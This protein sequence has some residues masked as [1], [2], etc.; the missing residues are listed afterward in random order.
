MRKHRIGFAALT[1]ASLCSAGSAHGVGTLA[2]SGGLEPIEQRLALSVG[3]ARTTL[4]TSTRLSADGVFGVVVPAPVGASLDWSSSA[5]FESLE[6]ATAPRLFPPDGVNAVC[7][8]DGVTH[9][10]HVVGALEHEE[11]L[12]PLDVLILADASAVTLWAAQAGLTVTPELATGLV[13][14]ESP[15]M[16]FVAALFD[17]PGGEVVT[18]TLRISTP[19]GNPE[20]PMV[21]T[22]AGA[23]D[24]TV[25]A[26]L[27]AEGRA[28]I[29]LAPLASVDLLEV[30]FEASG[31]GS[32]YVD[33]RRDAL[34]A[35]GADSTV[36][37]SASHDSLRDNTSIAEGTSS[38][39]GVVTAFFARASVYGDG[40]PDPAQ[41]TAI[42][43]ASLASSLV[44][45]P[46][47]PR[48]DLGVVDGIDD[49]VESALPGKTDPATLRCGDGADD[50]A[51]A[52]SGMVPASAWLTRHSLRVPA[53]ATGSVRL[54]EVSGGSEVS[55]VVTA[56]AVDLTGCS[57][58]GAGGA[59]AGGQPSEP[60]AGAGGPGSG[61][62]P[63][64]GIVVDGAGAPRTNYVPVYLVDGGCSCSGTERSYVDS[65]ETDDTD[66]PDAYYQEEEDCGG[67]TE[68][69]AGDSYDDDGCS[70][71]TSGTRGSDETQ[72][73]SDD[74]G[75]DTSDAGDDSG[76]GSDTSGSSSDSGCGS[77]TSGS[78][79]GCSGDTSGSSDSCGGDGELSAVRKV[80]RRPR[81]SVMTLSALL[82][83]VPV[84]R[85]TRRR[86]R[87]YRPRS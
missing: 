76:C 5:W 32:D 72:S 36:V 57:Q 11:P 67:D 3:S 20:L 8:G 78:S 9:A 10:F 75:G 21:L 50:L 77:D 40:L 83:I 80:R 39:Q 17:A 62:G 35:S 23:E 61:S 55:P 45:S 27:L 44:V 64:P 25:T 63:G 34:V 84:R 31:P 52:L 19:A 24:L 85:L 66:P 58:G 48:A 33:V 38:I 65:Y 87:R 86:R 30:V 47:C 59:G 22:Q 16:R 4:W 51:V 12:P 74:C 1:L 6:A 71:D 41:C 15:D 14:L 73:F 2:G 46:V 43:A 29:D 49:C 53:G 68:T 60:G 28:H 56:G 82:I 18:P 70:G 69:Y 7:P 26:W 54:V 81:L 79:D 42:G 37:E 13:A